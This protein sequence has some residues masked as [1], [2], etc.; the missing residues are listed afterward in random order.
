MVSVSGGVEPPRP[1]TRL[2][3]DPKI[4]QY[5]AGEDTENYLLLFERIARTWG[6]PDGEWACRLLPL[7]TGKALEE[8]MAMDGREDS[9]LP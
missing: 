3:R 9:F 8:Y 2:H 4:P 6:W 7:L 5:L 1:E